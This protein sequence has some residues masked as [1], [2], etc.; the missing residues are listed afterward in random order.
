MPA[1]DGR[2]NT[3]ISALGNRNLMKI[4]HQDELDCR[5]R[6]HR[7]HSCASINC[8]SKRLP[9][10]DI[11]RKRRTRGGPIPRSRTVTITALVPCRYVAYFWLGLP[12]TRRVVLRVPLVPHPVHDTARQGGKPCCTHR[13]YPPPATRQKKKCFPRFL[14]GPGPP[15]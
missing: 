4:T 7:E 11:P 2:D 1:S 6:M 8:S 10:L 3:H 14:Q 13:R 12:S 15:R 5:R 9:P